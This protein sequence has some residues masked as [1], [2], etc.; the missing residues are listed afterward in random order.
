MYIPR[1]RLKEDII[2]RTTLLI[3]SLVLIVGCSE[4]INDDTLIDKGGLKYHPDTKELYAGKTTKNR[5]GIRTIRTI[6]K[7]GQKL[8]EGTYKNGK[9]DGLET[10]WYENGHKRSEGTYKDGKIVAL[11]TNWFD[12]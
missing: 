9:L 12:N 5:D 1:R 11:Y 7:N 2:K 10:F 8:I 4:P 6:Y 3:S